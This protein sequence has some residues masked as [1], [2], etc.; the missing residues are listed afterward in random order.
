[1][2]AVVKTP[3]IEINV[4]GEEIPPRLL[5]ILMEEYGQDLRLKK[6]DGEEL[7]NVFNTQ[8]YKNIKGNMTPGKYLRIY[9][10]RKG[11]TQAQMGKALGDIPRQHISN[12]ENGLRTIS[13][14]M[15]RK[16]STLLNAPI[17]R[18]IAE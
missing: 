9:R 15:A 14:N 11:L 10:E 4:R 7:V 13:L 6:D 12:M 8:W 18:F 5:N 1:M 3:H 16:L 2:Q 17:D